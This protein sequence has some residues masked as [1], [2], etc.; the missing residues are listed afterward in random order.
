MTFILIT[1]ILISMSMISYF[2]VRKTRGNKKKVLFVLIILIEWIII[3]LSYLK[4]YELG[5]FN[6]S[7]FLQ[8]LFLINPWL[9]LCSICILLFF[10]IKYVSLRIWR[11]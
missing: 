7:H 2:F 5:I 8:A 6:N 3:S 10:L 4:L 11:R 9:Y 1:L